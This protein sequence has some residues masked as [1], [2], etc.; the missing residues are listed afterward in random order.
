MDL[1]SNKINKYLLALDSRSLNGS[2]APAGSNKSC[3][4]ICTNKLHLYKVKD[5]KP[6]LLEQF[7]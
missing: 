5:L 7:F 2:F 3:V 4:C 6:R 1:S